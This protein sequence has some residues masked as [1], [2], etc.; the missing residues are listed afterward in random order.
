MT[1]ASPARTRSLAAAYDQQRDH[2]PRYDGGT[3]LAL[4][5]DIVEQIR[6][7]IGVVLLTG[8]AKLGKTQMLDSVL[9]VLEDGP[10]RIER[11]GAA[12]IPALVAE[13]KGTR[14]DA[15]AM[16]IAADDADALD[17]PTFAALL[18]LVG[19]PVQL[20][21]V[22][23]TVDLHDRIAAVAPRLVD[24]GD[25]A[26]RE[27]EPLAS[28]DIAGYVALAVDEST[29]SLREVA[30]EE[31]LAELLRESGGMPERIN[32]VL[33]AAV[34]IASC[35]E[36]GLLTLDV[37][38]DAISSL[39][40]APLIPSPAL[41]E[42]LGALTSTTP[43]RP[44]PAAPASVPDQTQLS[45]PGRQ[46]S[47]SVEDKVEPPAAA[48]PGSPTRSP[49][50]LAVPVL[51]VAAVGA[52]TVLW[53]T[54]T[55]QTAIPHQEQPPPAMVAEAP[56]PA[57]APTPEPEPEPIAAEPAPTGS[58][59]P[60]EVATEPPQPIAQ[61][62]PHTD[63]APAPDAAADPSIQAV[64][65]ESTPVAEPPEEPAPTGAIGPDRAPPAHAP[66]PVPEPVVAHQDFPPPDLSPASSTQAQPAVAAL[67][68]AIVDGM[69][70]RAQ[71]LL[72]GG[73]VLAARLL[74]ERAASAGD[75]KGASGVG[76][77]YDPAFLATIDAQ[78]IS[79]NLEWATHWYRRAI[80]L[81]DPDAVGLLRGL[82]Q[83]GRP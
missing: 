36:Q 77:T 78:G 45:R 81:G 72:D 52:G 48:P 8:R 71:A 32:E 63:D 24:A 54:P 53:S 3:R 1:T 9:R 28:R 25:L 42:L 76:K 69:L 43:A 79:G 2:R 70:R 20:L 68:P 62:V 39:A 31:A 58:A 67:P 17:A 40:P 27:L 37:V 51:L 15:A 55:Q 14:N 47:A 73:D 5:D 6:C 13:R 59:L 34:A 64:A 29:T 57:S 44:A 16:L 7:R 50:R 46:P 4:R 60:T 10:M 82:P 80:M 75:G 21:L 74:Y 33:A 83:G 18:S 30:S 49:A 12:D 35:R 56:A 65:I 22:G 61:A 19:G 23:A 66:A 11:A 41:A 26:H 38:E